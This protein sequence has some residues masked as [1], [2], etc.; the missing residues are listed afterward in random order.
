MKCWQKKT[1]KPDVEES[2][3]S[4]HVD[5][6]LDVSKSISWNHFH[7][8]SFRR[9]RFIF[10]II[11]VVAIVILVNVIVIVI[12]IISVFFVVIIIEIRITSN[13]PRILQ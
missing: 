7:C 3:D 2:G 11:I 5:G 1:L 6:Q 4:G 9:H 10:A 12:A 8:R 13:A